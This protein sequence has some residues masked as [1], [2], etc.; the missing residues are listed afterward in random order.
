MS[1]SFGRIHVRRYTGEHNLRACIHQRH[2]GLT[3]T[4][5]NLTSY[6]LRAIWTVTATLGRLYSPRYCPCFRQL[7]MPYFSRTMPGYTR[8]GLCKPSSKDDRYHCF[9]G[10][11]VHQT[12][13][14]L[15]MSGILGYGWSA[16]YSSKF[17]STYSWHF[18]DSHTNCVE[19]NS[20]GW[21]PGP[22]WF[23]T[24]MHRDWLQ[25]MEA[26][27]HIESHTHRPYTVL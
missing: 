23:H 5:C 4:I 24:M 25:R 1:Y 7:H 26:S 15:N 12:C 9:P 18:V 19:G 17:S 10:L 16:T 8:Q 14:P 2:R 20:P 21:Y 27:H 6:V 22:L 11:H 13:H 3:S